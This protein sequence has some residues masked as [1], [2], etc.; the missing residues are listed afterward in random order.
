VIKT[1]CKVCLYIRDAILHH[2]LLTAWALFCSLILFASLF[3]TVD[4]T[5]YRG[6]VILN[7]VIGKNWL[8]CSSGYVPSRVLAEVGFEKTEPPPQ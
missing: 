1:A 5:V 7:D 2:K 4:A 8:N 3:V 6:R